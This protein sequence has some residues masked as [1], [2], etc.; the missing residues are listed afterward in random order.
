MK[1]KVHR[2]SCNCSHCAHFGGNVFGLS[3]LENQNSSARS[4]TLLRTVSSNVILNDHPSRL[5]VR[6]IGK[7]HYTYEVEKNRYSLKPG[8]FLIINNGQRYNSAMNPDVQTESFTVSFNRA[9]FQSVL[10]AFSQKEEWLLDN[11]FNLSDADATFFVNTYP[12]EGELQNLLE[13]FA[14]ASRKNV[15][16]EFFDT[17]FYLLA[18]QLLIA[19]KTVRREIL[20]I[21]SVKKITREELYRRL[22]RAKDFIR[23]HADQELKTET[24]AAQACLSP[25]HFMRTYK[26]AFGISPHQELLNVRLSKA[27]QLIN[28]NK[29]DW[30]LG[31]IAHE[32]GFSDL[33]S[34][35]KAFRQRYGVS[36]SRRNSC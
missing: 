21:P 13:R 36:P 11:P 25:F 2:L 10:T 24:I 3:P 31:R 34:F 30:T 8:R 6:W 12:V 28:F 29:H 32:A 14:R 26:R 5:S 19:Q 33:S 15:E 17:L 35:S 27:V 4:T 23:A 1:Q 22:C 7:G 9:L 18:E 16:V 20:A